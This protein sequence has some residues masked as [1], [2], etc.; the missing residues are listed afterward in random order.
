M[1]TLPDYTLTPGLTADGKPWW[2]LCYVCRKQVD[3][4]KGPKNSWLGIG[5]GMIRHKKCNPNDYKK[6]V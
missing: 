1:S 2:Q 4:I 3:F 5:N 6:V